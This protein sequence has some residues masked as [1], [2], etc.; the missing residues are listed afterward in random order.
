MIVEAEKT[1]VVTSIFYPEVLFPATDEMRCQGPDIADVL[2]NWNP[3][4]KL[5]IYYSL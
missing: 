2:E 4:I 3:K 1:A 5:K